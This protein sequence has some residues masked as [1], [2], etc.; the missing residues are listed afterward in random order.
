MYSI[1]G[2]I[3]EYLFFFL[4]ACKH[5]VFVGICKSTL[6]V[7]SSWNSLLNFPGLS[8]SCWQC[9][10]NFFFDKGAGTGDPDMPECKNLRI[11]LKN[12][13]YT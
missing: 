11:I 12:N 1:H 6:K 9:A 10:I 8:M 5:A 4:L 7:C 2:K 13:I 3:S